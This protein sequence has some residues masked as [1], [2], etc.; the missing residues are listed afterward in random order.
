MDRDFL[1]A[2]LRSF[3]FAEVF[4]ELVTRIHTG[5][6]ARFLVN[7]EDSEPVP[8]RSGIRQGCPLAPLLFLLVE[9]LLGLAIH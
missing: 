7:K 9:E 1:Y 5:T 6:T 4:I 2:A 8:V 3:R